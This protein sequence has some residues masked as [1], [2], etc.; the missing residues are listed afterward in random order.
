MPIWF[1]D[2]SPKRQKL[3]RQR[4]E[5]PLLTRSAIPESIGFELLSKEEIWNGPS[6]RFVFDVESYPNYFLLGC[7]CL[8][9]N[10]VICFEDGPDSY[11]DIEFL[12]FILFR[13][14]FIGFNSI[15]YD[16]PMVNQALRG[17][18]AP[19]LKQFSN[20]L[21]A[22]E[23]PE[24]D[25]NLA[26]INHIDL[27]EPLPLT[28]SLKLY[29]AR[30]HAERLQDLPYEHD[31][32]L[33][34]EEADIV[35]DYN[36]N[37]DLAATEILYNKMKPFLDLRETLS[38]EYSNDFRSKSDSQIAEAIIL[39]EIRKTGQKVGR[40]P[41][42][43]GDTFQFQA[44]KE[45]EFQTPVLNQVFETVKSWTFIVEASG[46]ADIQGDVK[47]LKIQL[48][49]QSYKMG[50]GGLHSSEKCL[51]V[52]KTANSSLIDVD[53]A[54]YYPNIKLKF[55][56]FPKHIGPI[57]LDIYGNRIVKRRLEAKAAKR[58]SEADGLKIAA[59][60]SFGKN[61]SPYSP[62]FAPDVLLHTTIG[63]QLFILM[64]IELLVTNDFNVISANTDG[65][66][67]D[68][69]NSRYNEFASICRY[70]ENRTGF[71]TEETR[72][73]SLHARDV[74]NYIAIKEDN[75]AKVKGVYAEVGS[76]LNSILSK[77]PEALVVS[78]ALQAFVG[79]GTPIHETIRTCRDFRRFVWVRNV[80]GGA[81]KDGQYLGR[82]VR[83]Y[84]ANDC[85]GTIN[86]VT[87]GNTVAN[88]E[89]GKPCMILP[90]E[91]PDDVNYD[92]YINRATDELYN[93][94]VYKKPEEQRLI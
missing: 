72:Y 23:R 36:V 80:R 60:G 61:G 6:R 53:V 34:K 21:I 73:R 48:G 14:L 11:I 66:V 38:S 83:W 33:T 3:A 70:W 54:S 24:F 45:L 74:N 43:A 59:N 10:K 39:S 30:C 63:G 52:Y 1:D 84:F 12:S 32:I 90:K 89:T 79:N 18:R 37:G 15:K 78:D 29:A 26:R 27:I 91:F 8:D 75:S 13:H 46:Y 31:R 92:W 56:L 81:E 82:V 51:S 77:N 85:T 65:V 19:E 4:G 9:T 62:I 57:Y 58:T 28:G 44:P 76:A 5:K 64:L 16:I 93:I 40:S 47:N 35:K 41:W 87:S 42:V 17:L 71:V 50:L 86:Y 22:D 2:S 25:L 20:K 7:K 88:S 55:G 68:V 94:G 69:P 67:T 49:N